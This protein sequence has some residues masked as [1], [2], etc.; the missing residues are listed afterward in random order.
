MRTPPVIE[1]FA[2]RTAAARLENVFL[3]QHIYNSC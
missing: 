3:F 2:A 1:D